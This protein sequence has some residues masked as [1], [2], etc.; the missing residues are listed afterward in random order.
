M[1]R[2]KLGMKKL[3]SLKAKKRAEFAQLIQAE[4]EVRVAKRRFNRILLNM[5]TNKH[6]EESSAIA[7]QSI[8]RGHVLNQSFSVVRYYAS[9]LQAFTRKCMARL[10]Y[11]RTVEG[12][13]SSFS[14]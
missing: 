13:T 6:L 4:W 14:L 3:D 5:R 2:R 1:I 11:N 7:I 12:N 8:W 10:R 9:V